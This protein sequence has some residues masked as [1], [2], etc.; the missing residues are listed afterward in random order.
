MSH[1][2]IYS[3][4]AQF[5]ALQVKK[6]W[7]IRNSWVH[8]EHRPGTTLSCCRCQFRHTIHLLP[9]LPS[10]KEG[11]NVLNSTYYRWLLSVQPLC[12]LNPLTIQFEI[13]GYEQLPVGTK[14]T[15]QSMWCKSSSSCS[16]C[17]FCCEHIHGP[18][19]IGSGCAR[20]E[21]G[22]VRIFVLDLAS[23]DAKLNMS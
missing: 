10:Y 2:A 18:G 17:A 12:L 4:S 19:P 7:P 8:A 11:V 6:I 21:H 20:R 22:S 5:Y 1:N 14:L 9:R 3:C 13:G 16:P 23:G 15:S